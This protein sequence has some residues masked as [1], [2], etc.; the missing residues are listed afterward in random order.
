MTFK[1]NAE[2]SKSTM[3][4]LWE[5]A[6]VDRMVAE[7]KEDIDTVQLF[8][9]FIEQRVIP[10][11][12]WPGPEPDPAATA[13]LWEHLPKND[14][15]GVDF[16]TFWNKWK[17][18]IVVEFLSKIM[19]SAKAKLLHGSRLG[20]REWEKLAEEIILHSVNL[21]EAVDFFEHW[22]QYYDAPPGPVGDLER[23][24]ALKLIEKK[25]GKKIIHRGPLSFQ[26]TS[27]TTVW[28][29]RITGS[30]LKNGRDR[31]RRWEHVTQKES[32]V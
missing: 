19:G 20:G 16:D 1:M 26:I 30:F 2:L 23:E 31:M 4:G 14:D 24:T 28:I 7:N 27:S 32:Q 13:K 11:Y 3:K 25:R 12:S 15:G 5:N 6:I 29:W 8:I 9:A 18:M 10:M 21:N 22:I 17:Q